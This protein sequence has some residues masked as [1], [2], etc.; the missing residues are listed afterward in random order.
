MKKIFAFAIA[1]SALLAASCNKE[2]T[3]PVSPVTVEKTFSVSAPVSTTK[4]ALEGTKTIVW[5]EGDAINV[6]AATSGNQ[7]AFTLTS[8]AGTASAKFSGAIDAADAQETTFYAVYPNVAIRTASLASDKIEFDQT[9]GNHQT[10]VKDGYDPAFGAMTA[11]LE[12]GSFA[13]RHGMAYFKL[14][15]GADGVHR[16]RIQSSNTR[17]SGR[18]VLVASTGAFS[19]IEGAKDTVSIAPKEGTFE[20]DGVYYIPVPVKNSNLGVVTVRYYFDAENS[21][22]AEE[23]NSSKSGV[24]IELG[25]IYDLGCPYISTEPRI[26]LSKTS[27]GGI[28]AAAADGLAIEN[29]YTLK[30]C[31]DNDVTVTPDGTVVT[32]ASAAGGTVTFSISENTGAAREGTISLSLAGGDPMVITVNQLAAGASEDYVWNFSSTEWQAALSQQ[33]EAACRETNGN[34]NTIFDVSYDGLSY[35]SG[36]GN[37]KWSNTGY[38]MPNGG[39]YYKASGKRR[40]WSFSTVN[41]GFVYVTLSGT[42]DSA[43]KATVSVQHGE[44]D[45]PDW[46]SDEVNLSIS[47]TQRVEIAVTSGDQILF[48]STGM[49]VKIIEFHQNK[50]TE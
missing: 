5:S 35:T 2:Y 26:I 3:L 34:T 7:Y 18:P 36:S 6:I 49:Q 40:Y 11:I 15:I 20:K 48:L 47:D 25:K 38:I 29:A 31:T 27:V 44:K 19:A 28:P 10:A 50:L 42:G 37:G 23:S 17:F 14:R 33:A 4:T 46:T 32:A 39:G 45:T 9:L 30:N 16:V 22:W 21:V 43:K 13:F 8:G 1:A 41:D 24:K 12:N